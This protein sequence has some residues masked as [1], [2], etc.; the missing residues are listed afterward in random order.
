MV[1]FSIYRIS[2][3]WLKLE[4]SPVL[5]YSIIFF[6]FSVGISIKTYYLQSKHYIKVSISVTKF[7]RLNSNEQSSTP[8][9]KRISKSVDTGQVMQRLSNK[10]QQIPK[11]GINITRIEHK[12]QQ[13]QKK[14]INITRIE[15][16]YNKYRRSE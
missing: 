2:N 1:H 7:R 15:K 10:I 12:I 13:I 6:I 11:K 9:P 3:K 16:K 4:S 5:K 8:I 14:W